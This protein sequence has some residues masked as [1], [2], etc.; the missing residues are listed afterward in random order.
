MVNGFPALSMIPPDSD[1]DA[2]KGYQAQP[3]YAPYCDSK[4]YGNIQC[5]EADQQGNKKQ[6][7]NYK[8]IKFQFLEVFSIRTV[9]IIFS[10]QLSLIM[11]YCGG[12]T[13]AGSTHSV[14]I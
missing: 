4:R 13:S 12:G 3:G 8:F 6:R 14:I 2:D 9:F 10:V 1:A 7:R 5:S 11:V